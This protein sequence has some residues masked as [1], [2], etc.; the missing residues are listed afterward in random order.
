MLSNLFP[1]Y[2]HFRGPCLKKTPSL[3]RQLSMGLPP[4]YSFVRLACRCVHK[5]QEVEG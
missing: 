3:K 5:Q 2:F 1:R 4:R